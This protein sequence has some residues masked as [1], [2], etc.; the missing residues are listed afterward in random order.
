MTS[1][2]LREMFK[3]DCADMCMSALVDGGTSE[4]VKRAQMGSGTSGNTILHFLYS[5]FTSSVNHNLEIM[6]YLKYSNIKTPS[7]NMGIISHSHTFHR[8]NQVS[9]KDQD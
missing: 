4:H 6:K 9:L 5:V 2:S 8:S 7:I 3:G 1:E